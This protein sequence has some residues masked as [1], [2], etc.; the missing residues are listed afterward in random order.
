MLEGLSTSDREIG[1]EDR[2]MD[3]D[4]GWKIG[5]G[6]PNVQTQGSRWKQRP[7]SRLHELG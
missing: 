6:L 4:R 2:G 5:W 7:D 1:I 3:Q